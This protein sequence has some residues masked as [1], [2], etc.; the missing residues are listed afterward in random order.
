[1]SKVAI[2]DDK[3]LIRDFVTEIVETLSP[4]ADCHPYETGDTFLEAYTTDGPFDAVLLDNTM[5][6]KCGTKVVEEMTE[7][8]YPTDNICI[9]S[10]DVNTQPEVFEALGKKYGIEYLP[11]PSDIENI[12]GFLRRKGIGNSE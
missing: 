3:N 2:V 7:Q 4:K 6:G 11:K 12:I 9:L 5:P 1:M 10:S 8:G